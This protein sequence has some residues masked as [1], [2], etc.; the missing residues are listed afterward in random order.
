MI[1]QPTDEIQEQD[2]IVFSDNTQDYVCSE[3]IGLEA[4][5][6]LKHKD[7]IE[8]RRYMDV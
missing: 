2:V 7:I 3:M 5:V 1:L 6:F 8:I 4:E